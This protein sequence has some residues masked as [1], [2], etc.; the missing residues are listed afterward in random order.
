MNNPTNTFFL[1]LASV[2]G[3]LAFISVIGY[4]W[5]LAPSLITGAIAIRMM[6]RKESRWLFCLVLAVDAI[7][8]VIVR[9]FPHESNGG[10][11]GLGIS[12]LLAALFGSQ[13]CAN[14]IRKSESDGASGAA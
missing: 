12:V 11:G 7:I 10:V 2:S 14:R 8:G 5:L 6:K 1:C 4:E 13:Y 3:V 9:C